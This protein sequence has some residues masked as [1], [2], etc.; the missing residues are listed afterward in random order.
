MFLFYEKNKLDIKQMFLFHKKK[1]FGR[2]LVFKN[3][4]NN[5]IVTIFASDK[6]IL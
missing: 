1:G 3:F 4:A 2:K 5:G 6:D